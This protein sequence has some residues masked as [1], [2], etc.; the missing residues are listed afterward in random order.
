MLEL[1]IVLGSLLLI[2]LTGLVTMVI[3]PPLMVEFGLWVLAAGLMLGIPSGW[4]YHVLL[5]RTLAANMPVPSHWWR[6]P[7]DLHSL[8]TVDEYHRVRPWFVAGAVGFVLCLIG[9]VAAIAG[10]LVLRFY[11]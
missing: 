8:L 9:G 11:P 4:W 1:L 5:Y 10:M 2:G 7:V 3:T 6:R